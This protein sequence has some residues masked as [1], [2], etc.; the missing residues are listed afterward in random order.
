MAAEDDLKDGPLPE[1]PADVLAMIVP[2][3][4]YCYQKAKE[5]LDSLTEHGQ[6]YG[7]E[8]GDLT[9]RLAERWESLGDKCFHKEVW[10]CEKGL[11]DHDHNAYF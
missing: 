10:E 5:V 9:L 11:C 4:L 8:S 6:K 7:V 1:P 2:T 3:S